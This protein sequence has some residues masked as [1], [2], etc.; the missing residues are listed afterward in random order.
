MCAAGRP[1]SRQDRPTLSRGGPSG[2]DRPGRG[3]RPAA[4]SACGCARRLPG[5]ARQRPSHR[6]RG[7]ARGRDRRLGSRRRAGARPGRSFAARAVST[8]FHGRDLFAPASALL[9]AGA[10]P[11][12][13]G[14][15]L[16]SPSL[17]RLRTHSRPGDG[18][19][20]LR[21]RDRGR[22]IRQRWPGLAFAELPAGQSVDARFLVEVAGDDLPEWSARLVAPTASFCPGELGLIGDSWGQAALALNGASAA[23]L[24]GVRRGVMVTLTPFDG[25]QPIGAARAA[26]PRPRSR[27]MT[28][29]PGQRRPKDGPTSSRRRPSA[30]GSSPSRSPSD[31]AIFLASALDATRAPTRA[32]A[33]VP[34]RGLHA[35]SPACRL[36]PGSR[37]S[38]G[39]YR[40]ALVPIRAGARA[41]VAPPSTPVRG[42]ERAACGSPR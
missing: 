23:E 11:A 7:V 1:R 40:R 3:H 34:A 12:S 17:V 37:P 10:E 30:P 27:T 32:R 15:A 42:G 21:P 20:S 22:P 29:K 24:L 41:P 13:L 2:G 28:G 4:D 18:P 33:A 36:P 9:A 35:P 16:D 5:R 26:M 14:R 19:G 8:T 25:G 31:P 6:R 38:A 39:R